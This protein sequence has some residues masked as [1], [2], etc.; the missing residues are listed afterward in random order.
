VAERLPV[1]AFVAS[2]DEGHLLRRSL[3]SLAFCDELVVIDIDSSDDTA[4]VA[5][6]NGARV[7][8]SDY[9]PIA[10]WARVPLVAEARHDWL[11]F[12]DPDEVVPTALADELARLLPEIPDDVG[13]VWAPIRFHVGGRPLRGTIW[14]G[15]NRRRLLVR[16]SGV[17]LSP[18]VFGG[19]HLQ[20][21]FRRL[22]LP[23]RDETAIRHYWVD[24]YRDW[25]A[26]HRRYLALQPRDR[27][28]AGIVTGP[29]AVALAPFRSFYD[30]YVR[31]RGYRDGATGL[32]LSLLWAGFSTAAEAGLLL[33][34][35]R[36]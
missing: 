24:G 30:C 10:E 11:L 28:R 14:G 35:R 27:A 7:V 32:A 23:W 1:S 3:P 29:R 8:R 4:A 36:R 9:V 16:R 22:D 33:E 15:E 26:K 5:E 19:T 13:I 20:P 2:R 17:D 21:G 31:Q 25:V 18:T 12:T 34:L 6:A